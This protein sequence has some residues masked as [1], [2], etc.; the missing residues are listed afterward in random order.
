MTA[1][2]VKRTARET[3]H[4]LVVERLVGEETTDVA[5]LGRSESVHGVGVS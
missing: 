3:R 4:A 5:L 2:V 1:G